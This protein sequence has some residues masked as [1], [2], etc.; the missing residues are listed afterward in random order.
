MK[1]RTPVVWFALFFFA[2]FLTLPA[3]TAAAHK[4]LIVDFGAIAPVSKTSRS[5]SFTLPVATTRTVRLESADLSAVSSGNRIPAERFTF[6]AAHD[7]AKRNNAAAGYMLTLQLLPSDPPGEYEGLVY[8]VCPGAEGT[9][10]IPVLVKVEIL[11]WIRLE[12]AN[13]NPLLTV[14]ASS[15]GTEDH[16]STRNP[17]KLLLASNAPWCLALRIGDETPFHPLPFPLLVGVGKN[18]NTMDFKEKIFPGRDYRTVAFGN[19]TVLG[20]GASD[21]HYW[22]E[23][24]ITAS[25]DHW[26]RYPKGNYDFRLFLAAKTLTP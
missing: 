16:L 24:Y 6:T 4:P 15:M 25:I 26:S 23:L 12:P 10:S 20:D 5:V 2:V 3:T 8:A 7:T 13:D 14:A 1:K 18:L 9:L 21:A 19:P 11:P 17:V 22:T